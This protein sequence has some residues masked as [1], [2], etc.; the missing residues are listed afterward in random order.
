MS[1]LEKISPVFLFV[2]CMAGY[3]MI[4]IEAIKFMFSFFAGASFTALLVMI[5]K[6]YLDTKEFKRRARLVNRYGRLS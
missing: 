1:K 2:V 4:N 6:T 5:I 3:F